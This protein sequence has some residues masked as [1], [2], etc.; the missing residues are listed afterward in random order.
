MAKRKSR[1]LIDDEGEVR[2]L[3]AEDFK[4]AIPFSELPESLKKTL[5]S[6]K[7]GPGT[8][9]L[10]PTEGLNGPPTRNPSNGMGILSI[11]PER[12]S[13]GRYYGMLRF[14]TPATAKAAVAGDPGCAQHDSYN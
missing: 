13:A 9:P 14:S 8:A 10:K 11:S 3:T 7:R 6:R 2:E 1:P 5:S 12:H 4:R